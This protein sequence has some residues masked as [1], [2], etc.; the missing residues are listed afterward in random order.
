MI[1]RT[2]YFYFI[3]LLVVFSSC[4]NA[5]LEDKIHSLE[6]ENNALSELMKKKDSSLV[7]F[8]QTIGDIE[9]SIEQVN[10]RTHNISTTIQNGV[11]NRQSRKDAIIQKIQFINTALEENNKSLKNLLKSLEKSN[12]KI[13]ALQDVILRLQDRIESKDEQLSEIKKEL[14]QKNFRLEDLNTSLDSLTFVSE[15]QHDVLQLQKDELETAF[16]CVG[17]IKELRENNVI[18]KEGGVA[19]IGQTIVMSKDF[20]KSYFTKIN[21]GKTTEIPLMGKKAKIISS[22]PTES[23]ELIKGKQLKKLIIK[24]PTLFWE[25]SKYLVVTVE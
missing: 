12:I 4:K 17:S 6:E 21:I 1:V 19:K 15:L 8:F 3:L 13:N 18:E 23:Y 25:A 14:V 22:H 11:E 2:H 9:N 24:N 20:N 7:I 10:V 16:Y 5:D